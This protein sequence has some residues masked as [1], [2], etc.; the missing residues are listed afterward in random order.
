MKSLPWLL[1][2]SS[3]SVG[4]AVCLSLE[5]AKSEHLPLPPTLHLCKPD[6]LAAGINELG[7]RMTLV[8]LACE[9]WVEVRVTVLL[10]SILY[11]SLGRYKQSTH[12]AIGATGI[13]LISRAHCY[14]K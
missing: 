10:S 8:G 1:T 12:A 11:L 3:L 4:Y 14:M 13:P 6:S 9:E 7:H 2:P 5:I